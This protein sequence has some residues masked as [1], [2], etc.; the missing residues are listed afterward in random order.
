MKNSFMREKCYWSFDNKTIDVGLYKVTYDMYL[1]KNI[2]A[3]HLRHYF[4]FTQGKD[5][6]EFEITVIL[7]L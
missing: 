5:V 6:I 4:Q 2:S 1:T 7:T 3:F